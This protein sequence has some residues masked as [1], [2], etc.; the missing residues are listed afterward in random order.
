MKQLKWLAVA[1]AVVLLLVF[2]TITVCAVSEDRG[3]G[4]LPMSYADEERAVEAYY[5]NC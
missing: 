2:G 1:L 5:L 3:T 4:L